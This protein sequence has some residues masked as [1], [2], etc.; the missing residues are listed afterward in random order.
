VQNAAPVEQLA[1]ATG[2]VTFFRTIGSTIGT[3]VYGTIM[4]ATMASGFAALDLSGVPETIRASLSDPQVLTNTE[5][6]AGIVGQASPEQAAA[7]QSAADAARGVLLG[8]IQHIFFFCA[9]VSAA[10]VVL[11]LLFK[12]APMKVVRLDP[13]D[14]SAPESPQT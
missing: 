11:S 7:V 14:G 2:T 8:G 12:P 4:T 9:I 6:L 13:P 3:A 1:A 10:A 5:T